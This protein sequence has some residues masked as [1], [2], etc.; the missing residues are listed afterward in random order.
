MNFFERDYLI[1]GGIP[2]F[3]KVLLTEVP[4]SLIDYYELSGTDALLGVLSMSI[5][6]F[7]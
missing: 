5:E 2:V 6:L 1:G 3:F 7:N 4:L